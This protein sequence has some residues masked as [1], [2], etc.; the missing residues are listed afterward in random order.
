MVVK[1]LNYLFQTV[2]SSFGDVLNAECLSTRLLI[3]QVNVSRVI[4]STLRSMLGVLS[5]YS[6]ACAQ[7]SIPLR[8]VI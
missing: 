5:W 8:N 4:Q 1:E 2:C 3:L 7:T 6:V